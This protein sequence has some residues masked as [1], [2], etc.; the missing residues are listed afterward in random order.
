MKLYN[1]NGDLVQVDIRP[2]TKPVKF[3]SKSI[4][5]GKVGQYLEQKYPRDNILEEFVIPGSRLSVDFFLP[6]RGLVCEIQGE[7]H[8]SYKPFFHGDLSTAGGYGKQ[9]SKDREK[10][11]WADMNGFKLVE[12]RTEEDLGQLD[13]Q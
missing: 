1:I 7:Q 6:K 13:G 4:L 2:S 3:K 10:A 8:D 11:Q 5:Q 12:I 9:I